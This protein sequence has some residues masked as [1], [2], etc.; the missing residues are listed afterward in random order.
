M[1]RRKP[2]DTVAALR[3]WLEELRAQGVFRSNKL[4]AGGY[5]V[6]SQGDEDG[7]IAEVFAKIGAGARGFVEIGCGDGRENNTAALLYSG[8]SGLWV[9]S[10]IRACWRAKRRYRQAVADGHLK[11]IWQTV[12]PGNINDLVCVPP[13]LLSIDIDGNDAHVF[14]ALPAA[15]S[16]VVVVEYNARLGPAIDWCQSYDPRHR[17]DGTSSFGASLA[18]WEAVARAKGYDLVGCTLTGVNAILVRT[19]LVGGHFPWEHRAAALWEPYRPEFCSLPVGH[20]DG[21]HAL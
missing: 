14:A 5:R 8:W 16:R 7:M 13:D 3:V 19:D 2:T 9:D 18:H 4:A 11:V 15:W 17:W 21:R 12:T 6:F 20:P 1:L 10:D